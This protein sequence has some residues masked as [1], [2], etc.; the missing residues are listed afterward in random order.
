MKSAANSTWSF[1]SNCGSG[2]TRK[3]GD[4]VEVLPT[5]KVPALLDPATEQTAKIG[6]TEAIH[7]LVEDVEPSA[8]PD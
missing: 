8:M 6:K 3:I 2:E 7:V 1:G 5:E 4:D